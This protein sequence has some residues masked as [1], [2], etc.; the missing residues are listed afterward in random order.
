MVLSILA[1]VMST[2]GVICTA[3][4]FALS[5]VPTAHDIALSQSAF[6]IDDL[7]DGDH[8]Q[9][10][11]TV[12]PYFS[13]FVVKRSPQQIKTLQ[14]KMNIKP[15]D[16]KWEAI[17]PPATQ[18]TL[19]S[20]R[21]DL[22]VFSVRNIDVSYCTPVNQNC[23]RDDQVHYAP[24]RKLRVDLVRNI[25]FY[26]DLKKADESTHSLGGIYFPYEQEYPPAKAFFSYDLSGRSLSG[27]DPL[28]IPP[29]FYDGTGQLIIGHHESEVPGYALMQWISRLT[30]FHPSANKG[31]SVE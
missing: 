31:E 28:T 15:S 13:V 23:W 16:L 20:I 7:A 3:I 11:T 1:M 21:T 10:M 17:D 12:W 24:S 14:S 8:R 5:M 29:H 25:S 9:L 18:N 6:N 30:S 2:F 19:R 4:P 22:F 26:N 27:L